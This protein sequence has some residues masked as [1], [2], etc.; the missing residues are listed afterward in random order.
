MFLLIVDAG[1]FI[2]VFVEESLYLVI[3]KLGAEKT[4]VL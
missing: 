1:V 4:A 2:A 3:G